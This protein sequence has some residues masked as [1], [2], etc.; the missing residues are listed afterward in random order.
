MTNEA[1]PSKPTETPDPATA[2]KSAGMRQADVA[3]GENP[4]IDAIKTSPAT[5]PDDDTPHRTGERQARE[6][7]ENDPPA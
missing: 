1:T 7:A 2:P 4:D 6:N 3:N 5:H